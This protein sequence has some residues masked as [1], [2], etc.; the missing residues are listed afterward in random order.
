MVKRIYSQGIYIF[1]LLLQ[2]KNNQLLRNV[3]KNSQGYNDITKKKKENLF[4]VLSLVK[5]Q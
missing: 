4:F 2:L 3:L 5:S 1:H